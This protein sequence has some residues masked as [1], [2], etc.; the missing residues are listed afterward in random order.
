MLPRAVEGS[1]WNGQQQFLEALQAT[2]ELAVQKGRVVRYRGFST[3]RLCGVQNG[4][5]EYLTGGWRWPQGYRHYVEV[6]N[7]RPSLAFVEA[8][9]G[10]ELS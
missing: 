4:S 1:K 5:I 9:L 2:E 6:H 8:V 7:V 10:T 3:C